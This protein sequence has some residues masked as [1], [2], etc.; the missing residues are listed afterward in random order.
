[1]HFILLFVQFMV[2]GTIGHKNPFMLMKNQVP[3]YTTA[4]GTQSS[5]ATIPVNLECAK[6]KRCQRT[7]P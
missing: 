4:L 6:A 7:D 3:G 2:A 5:A 1:M